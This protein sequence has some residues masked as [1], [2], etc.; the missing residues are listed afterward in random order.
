MT[1]VDFL[2]FP[3]DQRLQIPEGGHSVGFLM[4]VSASNVA[5]SFQKGAQLLRELSEIQL[6]AKDLK[7][8]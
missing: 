1:G 8:I 4:K 7:I 3:V 6:T 5:G 2:F